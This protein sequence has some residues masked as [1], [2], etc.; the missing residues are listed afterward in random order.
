MFSSPCS[1]RDE[2]PSSDELPAGRVPEPPSRLVER[3][4]SLDHRPRLG[5]RLQH[6]SRNAP[7][8][9][10]R[11]NTVLIF[12]VPSIPMSHKS[13]RAFVFVS[14]KLSTSQ[15]PAP[16][17][18]SRL[19]T[20]PGNPGSRSNSLQELLGS[21]PSLRL[22]KSRH[23]HSHHAAQATGGNSD[24]GRTP[25]SKLISGPSPVWLRFYSPVH[26]LDKIA[27]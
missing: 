1:P 26:D 5:R 13:P 7:T 3:H 4:L 27:E 25:R 6:R 10:A 20:P 17:T 22:W 19:S 9:T 18:A 2:D 8:H 11:L 21:M 12:K 15:G 24:T 16:Q 23:Q 14:P